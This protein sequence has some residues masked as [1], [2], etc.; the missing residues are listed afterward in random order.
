MNYTTSNEH[1]PDALH[2]SSP[3]PLLALLNGENIATSYLHDL[4]DGLSTLKRS[5]RSPPSD[6]SGVEE[7]DS[8]GPAS[9]YRVSK[10]PQRSS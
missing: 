3:A 6:V 9:S 5:A 1:S 10:R 4:H 8:D 7:E 2:A